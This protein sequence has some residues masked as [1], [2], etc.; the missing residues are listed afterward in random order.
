MFFY[1]GALLSYLKFEDT[2][3]GRWYGLALGAFGAAL[4]SKTAVAPM[5]LVLLVIAWWRR[6]RVAW[7]DLRRSLPF[8]LM[9]AVLGMVTVWFQSHKAIGAAAELVRAD[10]FWARLAG[11]GWAVWFYLCKVVLPLNLIFV[12]PRWQIDPRNVLSWLPLA[13]LAAGLSLCWRGRRT[14]GKSLLFGL[15][16]FVIMLLPVLGFLNIY[17][18]RYSLVADHWQYFAILGP[19]ALAAAF[20]RKPAPAAALLLALG[21][22]TWRQCGMYHDQ[23]TL[24]LATIARNPGSVLARNNLGIALVGKGNTEGAIAQYRKALEINPDDHEVLSNLGSALFKKGDLDQAIAQE[25]RSLEINPHNAEARHNLGL[26]LFNKGDLD[27]AIAQY[28]LALEIQ[29]DLAEARRNLGVAL[30]TKGDTEGA[31][32]QYRMILQ[33]APDNAGDLNNLGHG[34]LLKGDLDGAIACFQKAASLKPDLVEAW[35]S[36]GKVFLQKG[37]WDQAIACGRQAM[38]INP[39]YEDT[40]ASLGTAL[41]QKGET[42]EAMAVWQQALEIKPDQL[43]VLNNLAWLLA[44][45]HDASLRN[46]AKAVALAKQAEQLS[47]GANPEIL[48]TL[49]AAYAESGNYGLASVTA[50]RALELAVEQKNDALAATLQK[51]IKLYE[52]GAPAREG[53]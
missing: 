39:R 41:F 52:A 49:A 50:R 2:G 42:R 17:F 24:W 28:R 29:P 8:F 3:K 36:L 31:I 27:G 11:A 4:L 34:L 1:L 9:A 53:K 45:T 51:E 47:G 40:G 37:D 12:Y 44:T 43:S 7:R 10:N 15:G 33:T 25:R 30:F 23:E 18:M 21:V 48:R 19:I 20:P 32:A 22:L 13:L 5:P 6:G 14:W 46:G 38:K 16:Y 26:A 35:Y